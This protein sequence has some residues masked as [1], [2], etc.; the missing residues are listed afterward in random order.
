MEIN[1]AEVCANLKYSSG[2]LF[3]QAMINKMKIQ[4]TG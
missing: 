1:A 2:F 4:L 3:Q